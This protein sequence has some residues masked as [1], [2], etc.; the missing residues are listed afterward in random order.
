MAKYNT[1]FDVA[2]SLEHDYED[3]YDIP[4]S[5][6]CDALEKRL[7]YLRECREDSA[8]GEAFGVCDTYEIAD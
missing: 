5:D 8:V 2:F 1:M 4:V 7:K 3:P 6:L